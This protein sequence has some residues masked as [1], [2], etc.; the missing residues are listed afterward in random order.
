MRKAAGILMIIDAI[1]G[2]GL[3]RVIYSLQPEWL[4][5]FEGLL[6]WRS[7]FWIIFVAI[8][9]VYTFKGKLWG[10]CLASSILCIS[11]VI[12]PFLVWSNIL[13]D[14]SGEATNI[15]FAIVMTL[16][17][18]TTAIL[19]VVSIRLKKGEWVSQLG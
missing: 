16:F 12:L 3:V 7:T 18:L 1:I 6:K 13:S 5:P 19:P 9:G 15:P 14:V 2:L 4:V 17:F 11:V 8:G 10:L